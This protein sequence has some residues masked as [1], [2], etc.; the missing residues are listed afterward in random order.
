MTAKEFF[1]LVV[2][3]RYAQKNYFKT[4]NQGYLDRSKNL[5]KQVDNEIERVQKLITEPE[6]DF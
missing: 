5:E 4:R 1:E 3:M 2:E 6:L